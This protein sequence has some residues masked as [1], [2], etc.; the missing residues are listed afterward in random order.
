MDFSAYKRHQFLWFSKVSGRTV[1]V[2][3]KFLQSCKILTSCI[4]NM[5]YEVNSTNKT[6]PAISLLH[7]TS[8]QFRQANSTWNKIAKRDLISLCTFTKSWR[9]QDM[10]QVQRCSEYYIYPSWSC[11]LPPQ[12]LLPVRFPQSTWMQELAA[13]EPL[14]AS[15]WPCSSCLQTLESSPWFDRSTLWPM[16]TPLP[17]CQVGNNSQSFPRQFGPVIISY[18]KTSLFITLI[19]YI[20]STTCP[21]IFPKNGKIKQ[22]PWRNGN[23]PFERR[24]IPKYEIFS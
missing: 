1:K 23:T 24:N 12:V 18:S 2:P 8:R 17:L 22:G 19:Q 11:W 20:R 10:L 3:E 13:A 7:V 15:W 4:P 6:L 14:P 16:N 21:H 9:H 5:P